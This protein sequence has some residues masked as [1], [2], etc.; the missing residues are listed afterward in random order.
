MVQHTL[1]GAGGEWETI[2]P[3]GVALTLMIEPLILLYSGHISHEHLHHELAALPPT[4][5]ISHKSTALQLTLATLQW[6]CCSPTNTALQ[7]AST[8]QPSRFRRDCPEYRPLVPLPF[9]IVSLSGLIICS[10]YTALHYTSG[11]C[12][13]R[14]LNR[15]TDGC[16]QQHCT[17]DR[18]VHT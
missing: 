1:R 15:N 5:H 6:T 14:A 13:Q 3:V 17:R 7:K 8:Y 4:G 2:L 9:T 16:S 12:V 11:H 10:V 18:D